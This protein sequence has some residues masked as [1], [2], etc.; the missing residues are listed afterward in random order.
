MLQFDS[1]NDFCETEMEDSSLLL[2][3]SVRDDSSEAIVCTAEALSRILDWCFRPGG[4][5]NKAPAR[6]ASLR[7]ISMCAVM[8]PDLLEGKSYDKIAQNLGVTKKVISKHAVEFHKRFKIHSRRN[9]TKQASIDF[10][11]GRS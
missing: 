9:R 6:A 8:R 2:Q 11:S 3:N 10:L 5:R 4:G 7:F 1:L